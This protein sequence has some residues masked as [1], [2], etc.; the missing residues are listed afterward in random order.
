MV[1]AIFWKLAS[2]LQWYNS[3]FGT[4]ANREQNPR[5]KKTF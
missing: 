2:E 4:K 5:S 1:S 3:T